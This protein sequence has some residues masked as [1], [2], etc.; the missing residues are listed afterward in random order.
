M[1]R[2][3][4]VWIAFGALLGMVV[5]VTFAQT[6]PPPA[7][8]QSACDIQLSIVEQ[9]RKQLE[10]AVGKLAAENR[11]L[12]EAAGKTSPAPPPKTEEKK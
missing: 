7:P 5:G 6:A 1:K 11:K 2:L 3:G 9:N 10:E 8:V 12:T 4:L